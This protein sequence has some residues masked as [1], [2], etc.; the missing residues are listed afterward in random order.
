MTAQ[1]IRPD[2]HNAG[3][4]LVELMIALVVGLLLLAGV[5][6]I[7][8]G[9]RES[10]D[11][12]RAKAH[13]QENARLAS[14]VLENAI[15]HAGFRTDIRDRPERLFPAQTAVNSP[16]FK[17]GAFVAGSPNTHGQSDTL[18]IRFQA[19]GGVHDCIGDEIGSPG[20]AETTDFELY[21]NDDSTL[22]CR[23]LPTA[24]EN[25]AHKCQA[26]GESCRP[27]VE[28][29]DRFEVRYGLDT[30]ATAGVDRYVSEL[31]TD[32]AMRVR[33]VRVQLLLRSPPNESVLPSA[34]KQ[35]YVFSDRSSKDFTDRLGRVL[36]D[37]TIALRN[38][39]P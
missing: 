21:V 26:K 28:N 33:S 2:R 23:V 35:T 19:E 1:P 7:L 11:A 4:S 10:F 32:D 8:L 37:Q 24:S 22:I 5:L 16:D 20:D 3:F 27:I 39:L 14:F 36:L 17:A 31:S 12:Q 29:V 15:A 9:N 38:A 18:R 13:I 25:S 34:T 6:Q 30:D